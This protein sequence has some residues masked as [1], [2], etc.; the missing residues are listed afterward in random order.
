MPASFPLPSELAADV[1]V[2]LTPWCPYCTMARRLL[3]SRQIAYEHID[4]S[5]NEA[6]RGW[7]RQASRQQTVPQ[8]FVRGQSVGG[9]TELSA[10]DRSGA[11]ARMLAK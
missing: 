8:I 7:L 9:F 11:L 2:Y 10:L 3:D 6:A 1:V 4:V 5:G